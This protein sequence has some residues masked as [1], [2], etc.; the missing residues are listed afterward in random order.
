MLAGN[1]NDKRYSMVESEVVGMNQG[2]AIIRQRVQLITL[3]SNSFVVTLV[4][5]S[6]SS[7]NA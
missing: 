7:S 4:L 2:K 6:L 3:Q 5:G 1:D